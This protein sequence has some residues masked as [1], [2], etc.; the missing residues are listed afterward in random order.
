METI[1]RR[2]LSRY[3][4]TYRIRNGFGLNPIRNKRELKALIKFCKSQ[5]KDWKESGRI[6][7]KHLWVALV[8]I[9]MYER[10]NV[11]DLLF[12]KKYNPTGWDYYSI[13]DFIEDHS[14]YYWS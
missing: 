7:S 11:R 10:G 6:P 8:T 3:S 2:L 12:I 13:W 4:E 5:V 14:G 1:V 9:R